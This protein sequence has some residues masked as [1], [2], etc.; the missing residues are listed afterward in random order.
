ME[1]NDCKP[2]VLKPEHARE[3]QDPCLAPARAEEIAN[4][5]QPTED[6]EWYVVGKEVG[7]VKH[8]G[9]ELLLPLSPK[10]D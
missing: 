1:I 7:N 6:F 8:Q 9:A 3:W 5:C 4:G 2:L 10:D